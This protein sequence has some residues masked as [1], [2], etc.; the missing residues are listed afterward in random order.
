MV[1]Y[2]INLIFELRTLWGHWQEVFYEQIFD[3]HR[4]N[5]YIIS[6]ITRSLELE[7]KIYDGEHRDN[8]NGHNVYVI[9]WN[10]VVADWQSKYGYKTTSKLV[11]LKSNIRTKLDNV[12]SLEEISNLATLIL[13]ECNKLQAGQR[14]INDNNG[15]LQKIY[16]TGLGLTK[17]YQNLNLR[18]LI[19]VNVK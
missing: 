12:N 14:E 17:Q 9:P 10:K 3:H 15:Y 18:I 6:T 8:F 5:N 2:S 4:D 16:I 13:T 11:I 19:N 7:L 1:P